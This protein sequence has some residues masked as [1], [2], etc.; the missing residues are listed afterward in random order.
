[1]L[2]VEQKLGRSFKDIGI[3]DNFKEGVEGNNYFSF[4]ANYA[5]DLLEKDVKK[6][7]FEFRKDKIIRF[8]K[9]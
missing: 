3:M 4:F 2:I 1:M 8:S 7:S 9:R 6:V 5:Y